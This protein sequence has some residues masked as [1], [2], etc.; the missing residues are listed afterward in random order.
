LRAAAEYAA[1]VRVVH[2]ELNWGAYE[3][4]DGAFSSSYASD[5]RNRLAAMRA[6]GMKVVLGL[7]LQYPPSWVFNYPNSR[8][9][10]QYG[11]TANVVNLTWNSTLRQKADAYLARVN[12]D[13]GLS[14][15]W[16]VRVGSGGNVETLY[17]DESGRNAYWA[18]NAN[19]QAGSPF[20]GWRPGQTSW[21]GQPFTTAQVGQ[22]YDWYLGSLVDGVNWQLDGYRRLGFTGYLQVLMPGVGS[23]PSEYNAA[24]AGYLGGTGDGLHTMGRGAVW[25]RL[26]ARISD[27][28]H[29][30]AYVSSVADGSGGNDLCS[31]SDA[32]VSSTSSAVLGWSA[33]R[34]ISYNATKY[35]LAK[36]GENPGRGDTNSYG[37]TMLQSAAA[38]MQ[39]CGFQGLMWAHDFNLYDGVSGVSLADY[40]AVLNSY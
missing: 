30:V 35:G 2:L 14:S 24:I 32:T 28:T 34:W 9:V 11:N 7:G 37:L 29:V 15:F 25:D 31:T 16:A 27:R 5:A 26:L 19:A 20:P 8:Y 21:N 1:G 17:P 38:Q 40:A 33:T 18:Y 36:N 3:P 6:A 10:D 4:A 39:S 23:R 12:A 13:L 22:W